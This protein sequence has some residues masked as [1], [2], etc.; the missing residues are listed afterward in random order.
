VLR[1]VHVAA[2]ENLADADLLWDAVHQAEA[3]LHGDGRVV[4]RASGTEPLVRVM[5]EA[6]SAEIANETAE[7]LVE[8]VRGTLGSPTTSDGGSVG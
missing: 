6:A 2:K 5:V 4:V 7:G 3:R 8:V 1:N